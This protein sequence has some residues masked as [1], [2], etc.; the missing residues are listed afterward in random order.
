MLVTEIGY[1][2]VFT[3]HDGSDIVTAVLEGGVQPDVILMDYRMPR[4]NGLEAASI[5]RD[6]RPEVRILIASADDDVSSA[7]QTRGLTYLQKPFPMSKLRDAL[8]EAVHKGGGSADEADRNRRGSQSSKS[9]GGQR[10]YTH[11]SIHRTVQP[12]L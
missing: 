11:S 6:A 9:G 8:K 3:G 5:I 7:I 2:V 12:T 10:R 1:R 4:M